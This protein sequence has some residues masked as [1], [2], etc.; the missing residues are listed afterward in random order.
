MI[1]I[2]RDL[3]VSPL[4]KKKT[5][6]TRGN[7]FRGKTAFQ[8]VKPLER[9]PVRLALVRGVSADY[10]RAAAPLELVE[11]WLDSFTEF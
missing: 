6:K 9:N 5:T 7:R 8:Q 10:L 11:I 3:N 1:I 4:K 2:K